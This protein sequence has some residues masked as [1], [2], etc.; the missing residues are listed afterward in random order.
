LVNS[1]VGIKVCDFGLARSVACFKDGNIPILTDYVATRWYRSPEILLGS[2]KYSKESDLWSIGCI[3]AELVIGKPLFPGTSTLNQLMKILELTGKPSKEDIYSVHSEIAAT[4]LESVPSIKPKS[5]KSIFKSSGIDE[6][7]LIDKLLQFNP[8]KRITV[9]QALEHAY[10]SDFHDKSKEIASTKA[11]KIS[12]DDNIKYTVKD[13]R[14]KLYD[15]ILKKK[16]EIKK[17]NLQKKK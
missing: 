9:E 14:Q 11:I 1:D 15:D 16:K 8:E 6:L 2:I 12:I 4:M 7:D 10:V 13:Y 3:L 5:M 17:K